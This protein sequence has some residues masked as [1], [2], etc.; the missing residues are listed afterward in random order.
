MPGNPNEEKVD[1]WGG[2]EVVGEGARET[3]VGAGS[4]QCKPTTSIYDP[5]H[6][7]R[8]EFTC[9]QPPKIVSSNL[10]ASPKGDWADK[11]PQVQ[12]G[13]CVTNPMLATTP[14]TTTT[15]SPIPQPLTSQKSTSLHVASKPRYQSCVKFTETEF[16]RIKAGSQRSGESIPGLL[17]HGYFKRPYPAPLLSREEALAIFRHLS[18]MQSTLS[19]IERRLD[20]RSPGE[21]R[22]ELED[23]Q[24]EFHL[25]K[26]Y[27]F[28]IYRGPRRNAKKGGTK[29]GK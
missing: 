16:L 12:F 11:V 5:T 1:V 21:F 10:S 17:K 4:E 6:F 29:N 15:D 13:G 9:G 26:D 28:W 24:E 14:I 20:A 19:E 27:I 18:R 23:I 22:P 3:C 7:V 2:R 8:R 25:L